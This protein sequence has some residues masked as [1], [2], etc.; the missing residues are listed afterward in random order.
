MG[1]SGQLYLSLP[2]N[3]DGRGLGPA[4]F[5]LALGPTEE[6]PL[7]DG[8]AARLLDGLVVEFDERGAGRVAL[9]WLSWHWQPTGQPKERKASP[10]PPALAPE[11]PESGQPSALLAPIVSGLLGDLIRGL[12]IVPPNASLAEPVRRDQP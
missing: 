5:G 3:A 7:G 4:Q 12:R 11:V 2:F 1:A 8:A 9:G 10:L 6:T